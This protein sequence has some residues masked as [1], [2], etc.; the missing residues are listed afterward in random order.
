MFLESV[1]N[2]QLTAAAGA[3]RSNSKQERS[4]R[5]RMEEA[6]ITQKNRKGKLKRINLEREQNKTRCGR[7]LSKIANLLLNVKEN[8][9]NEH[10]GREVGSYREQSELC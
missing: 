7:T 8:G 2:G 5:D 9:K 1:K 10:K 4:E 3:H 6:N